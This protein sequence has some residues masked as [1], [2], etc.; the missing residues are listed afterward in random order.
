MMDA[1]V[2]E[3]EDARVGVHEA[4]HE[5]VHQ[6]SRQPLVGELVDS[7]GGDGGNVQGTAQESPP[8]LTERPD[9]LGCQS[10]VGEECAA[11]R[12]PPAPFEQFAGRSDSS[13]KACASM[14]E[15][16]EDE[17]DLVALG[18]FPEPTE[19]LELEVAQ[20]EAEL[21][22][23][24]EAQTLAATRALERDPTAVRLG[25]GPE[26]L[27][28][29]DGEWTGLPDGFG[30]QCL[31]AQFC[32][33]VPGLSK[34]YTLIVYAG[35]NGERP[36]LKSCLFRLIRDLLD[37]GDL[38]D[39]PR[40]VTLIGFFLR[41]DLAML[42]DFAQLKN[43]VDSVGGRAGTLSSP[44]SL[45]FEAK[46]ALK[47]LMAYEGI[48]PVRVP[49]R[50]VDL[51]NH[52]P[53]GTNLAQLGEQL[54]LPKLSLPEGYTKDRMDLLLRDQ[55]KA[56]EQYALRDAEIALQYFVKLIEFATDHL[57]LKK[58]PMTAGGTAVRVFL[59][60]L[61][62]LQIDQDKFLGLQRKPHTRWNSRNGKPLTRTV[63]GAVVL[64]A[65]NE[66]LLIK[67]YHGGRNETFCFGPTPVGQYYDFDLTS[68]YPIGMTDLRQID[69]A[70]IHTST[71]LEDFLGDVAGF[72]YV[73]FEFPE[74]VR[75][76]VL[77]VEFEDRG[78]IFP[79]GGESYCT[80]AELQ[81]AVAL[82]CKIT[83]RHGVI[84]PWVEADGVR[85]MRDFVVKM[86]AL[87]KR[88]VKGSVDEQYAKLIANSL[89]GK[90]AQ[91][92]KERTVFD[93]RRERNVALDRSPVTNAIFAS[94]VT[95]FVR[96]VLAEILNRIPEG[97]RVISVTTDGF[98]TDVPLEE[99]D[100]SG[101]L[102]RRYQALLDA[103][104]PG[105]SM[106]EIKHQ[107]RQII[108]LKT[109]GQLTGLPWDDHPMVL[110]KA[111]VQPPSDVVDHNAYMVDL[112][113]NRQP[114]Q[115][116]PV[117]SFVSMRD[118]WVRGSDVYSINRDTQLNLEFDM[119]REPIHPRMEAVG[120]ASEGLTHLAFET[121]PWASVEEMAA[122][123]VS[124]DGWRTHGVLRT[125]NDFE[126]WKV[127][128][129]CHRA[130][131]AKR[132]S[133]QKTTN[134]AEPLVL[135]R[136]GV[137]A[138]LAQSALGFTRGKQTYASLVEVLASVGLTASVNDFK[139]GARR[140]AVEGSVPATPEVQAILALLKGL[141]P[142]VAFERL[143]IASEPAGA[144]SSP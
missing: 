65:L 98:L 55:R 39:W 118:Q 37:R 35:P 46:S 142:G 93:S 67:T 91:G 34:P 86:K 5:D 15:S 68:A 19:T 7:G 18:S 70:A 74:S 96:A 106:L 139:N 140:T 49:V 144:S 112:F 73:V 114:G 124:L 113:L 69:Y 84:C 126:S 22:A 9:P 79:R 57:G 63:V 21:E 95:G 30:N 116:S 127:F 64:L 105:A 4:V 102:A 101:P 17:L 48:T 26:L 1:H 62:S 82:G 43:Q 41:A 77:P 121:R 28:S 133:G 83:I 24:I 97:R 52:V 78:L 103:V 53:Q 136:R 56:F 61:K 29:L 33:R 111:G 20:F 87:R 25:E 14:A 125:V 92:L 54:N 104:D 66:S 123:R 109:R 135:L 110:A 38:T 50:F 27:V 130:R 137:V 143:L 81:A 71:C 10:V 100:L 58:L 45:I 128:D 31:S 13:A 138:V 134:F 132:Q 44:A 75:F 6:D 107:V 88:F 32:A 115:M 117:S 8:D 119:K 76:P 85:P 12:H 99:L 129:Q 72:A 3:K 80:A 42:G 141:F 90:T 16:G 59:D 120:D 11:F 89:Y 2:D 94:Y 131:R 122:C 51:G 60:S 47:T 108:A 23:E 40:Q 36:S